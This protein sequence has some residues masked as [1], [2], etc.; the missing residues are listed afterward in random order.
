MFFC[1][2]FDKIIIIYHWY[3]LIFFIYSAQ[4]MLDKTQYINKLLIIYSQ[5]IIIFIKFKRFSRYDI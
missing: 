4:R 5:I 2:F 1:L 3:S